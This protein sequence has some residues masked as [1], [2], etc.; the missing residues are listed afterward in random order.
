MGSWRLSR[1]GGKSRGRWGR[2]ERRWEEEQTSFQ[3]CSSYSAADRLIEG[4]E[5]AVHLLKTRAER[6]K[7]RST[8]ALGIAKSEENS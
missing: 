5:S 4:P 3:R 2:K 1:D 6:V 7:Q 8:I